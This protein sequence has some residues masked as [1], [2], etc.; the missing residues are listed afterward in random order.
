MDL[1]AKDH[2]LEAAALRRQSAKPELRGFVFENL[3]PT[4]RHRIYRELLLRP[5]QYDFG[6]ADW[7]PSEHDRL[8]ART[9]GLLIEIGTGPYEIYT[10]I[11]CTNGNIHEEAAA[12][13]YGENWFEWSV[14]GMQYQAMWHWPWQKT[15]V[16]SRRYSRL[17]KKMCLIVNTRGDENDPTQADAIFWTSTNLQRVCKVLTLNDFKILKVDFCNGLGYKYGGTGY[18][19]QTCLEPLKKCR[20]EKVNINSVP[21]FSL[22]QFLQATK[23]SINEPYASP[24]YAAELKAVIE[25]PKDAQLWAYRQAAED[26]PESDHED[27]MEFDSA[28]V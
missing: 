23:F 22:L 13:L 12:V 10:E 8:S 21:N 28:Y 11:M 5:K 3:P 17:I 9:E 19:G 25:G 24:C 14:Y 27:S 16:C 1:F 15:F 6:S 7:Y 2:P 26:E 20:A 4:V 18:F